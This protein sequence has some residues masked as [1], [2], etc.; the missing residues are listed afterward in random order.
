MWLTLQNAILTKDNLLIRKWKGSPNCGFCQE[1]EFVQHLFFY[2]PMSK[3][4]WSILAYILGH[5]WDVLLL[6]SSGFGSS[7]AY[8]VADVSI[9][10]VWRLF[11]L[12]GKDKK[13]CLLWWEKSGDSNWGSMFDFFYVDIL[14]RDSERRHFDQLEHGA[15]VLQKT[16]LFFH[17][18]G[19]PDGSDNRMAIVWNH[20][21][22]KCLKSYGVCL[23]KTVGYHG[24]TL[25]PASCWRLEGM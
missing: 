18:Q 11:A 22:E 4:I 16:A 10:W 20:L 15:E 24:S 3:Y 23:L 21:M 12:M 13:Q 6:S 25:W 5:Q 8:Q 2:C 14:D 7:G 19:R 9:L 17:Q 1:G